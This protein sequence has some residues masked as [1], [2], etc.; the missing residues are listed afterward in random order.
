MT[1]NADVSDE[2]S[3]A[4]TEDSKNNDAKERMSFTLSKKFGLVELYSLN[5]WRAAIAEL[6]GTAILVFAMVTI[7]ISSKETE[8]KTPNLLTSLLIAIIITIIVLTLF[9]ISG[10]H[11]NPVVSFSATLVGVIPISRGI[12]YIIAQ[13]I[14]AV[15]GALALKA[16]VGRSIEDTFSLGGCTLN[17]SAPGSNRPITISSALWMEIICTFVFLFSSVSLAFD[18]RR[19]KGLGLATVCSIMGSV[20]GLM[21]FVSTTVTTKKGYGGVGMNPAR[22]LGPA[23]V[24]G[25]HLWDGHWVFWV[26]P[27]IACLAF[28]L[29][30]KTI[31]CQQQQQQEEEA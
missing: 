25:G 19:V 20:V 16:V 31:P 29:Y 26:G 23:I 17:V 27:A 3:Q 2:E 8:T 12:V 30:H 14:G 6:L 13:C 9:P 10:G 5:V 22:C 7:V 11:V 24:R 15:L 18:E 1:G 4:R 21:V 28:Y